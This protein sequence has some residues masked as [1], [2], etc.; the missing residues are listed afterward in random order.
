MPAHDATQDGSE[1]DGE[2]DPKSLVLASISDTELLKQCLCATAANA[3]SLTAAALSLNTAVAT[4]PTPAATLLSS[5]TAATPASAANSNARPAT[6]L[7]T[8]PDQTFAL[9][10][11]ITRNLNSLLVGW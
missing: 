1:D 9:L 2:R 7:A 5:P 11:S 10:N 4:S 8:S 3:S 6:D